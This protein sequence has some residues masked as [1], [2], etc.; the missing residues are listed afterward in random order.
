MSYKIFVHIA[1]YRDPDLI[2]T[3]LD[4]FENSKFPDSLRVVVCWQHDDS[5]C[6]DP[7]KHL[8]EYIDVPYTESLGVCFARHLLQKK[9]QGET[10]SLQLDS[11]HRFVKHWDVELIQMYLQCIDKASEFPLITS[12]LPSFSSIDDTRD[13]IP[14]KM[15]VKQFLDDGPLIFRTNTI[16]NFKQLKSPLPARFFSGHFAFS[17]G[18]ICNKV[19]YDPDY[20]FFGEEINM[21]ARAYTH[22][23]DLYHPHKIIGWHQYTRDNRSTHWN[24]HVYGNNKDWSVLDNISKMKYRK[25]FNL[26]HSDIVID[27]DYGFGKVRTL[28]DYELYSGIN[29][30]TQSV[31]DS[32]F[33]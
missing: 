29:F 13:E 2:N 28:Q 20:Y 15:E 14:Y 25:L 16:K 12:Y 4:L 32:I 27:P 11:H 19:K 17:E 24:D 5:E 22:G 21:A 7:I 23:Y 1:S 26:E 6:L 8:I 31:I 30:K 3:V 10:Y 33:F 18:Q 9:Y